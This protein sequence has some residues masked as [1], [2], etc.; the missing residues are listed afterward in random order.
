MLSGNYHKK[1]RQTINRLQRLLCLP[2]NPRP[3]SSEADPSHH[4]VMTIVPWAEK[5]P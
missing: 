2:E 4:H 5:R 1:K 3:L